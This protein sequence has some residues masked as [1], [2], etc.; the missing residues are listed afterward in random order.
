[1]TDSTLRE[2]SLVL[3]VEDVALMRNMVCQSLSESGFD[4]AEAATVEEGLRLADE[5]RP[6]IILLDVV[7]PDGDG[8]SV[9]RQLRSQPWGAMMPVVMMTGLDDLESIA[10]AFDAGATDFITKP[11]TWGILGHRVA[12]IIRSSRAEERIRTL[13]YFDPLTGLPNRT[14]FTEHLEML[15][16][17]ARRRQGNVAILLLD[18]DRFKKINETLGHGAGDRLLQE[19][20]Q[21]LKTAVRSSDTI[22]RLADEIL[23]HI[24]RFGGDEFVVTL[25]DAHNLAG[26][27]RV[28]QRLL[29][30]VA[31]PLTLDGYELFPSASIGISFFPTDGEDTAELLKNADTAMYHAK[32]Q[33][34]NNFQFYAREMNATAM[35]RLNLESHLRR[36]LERQEFL[37]HYQPQVETESGRITGLEALIRWPHAELGLIPP[38]RFISL[39]EETGLIFDLDEWV[40]RT[41]VRQI[42]QWRALGIEGVKVAVNLSGQHFSRRDLLPLLDAVI[43][44]EEWLARS[45]ELEIT[46]GV[47]MKEGEATVDI[48][49]GLRQRGITLAIDDFGTGYSSLSYLRRFPIDCLKIDKSFIRDTPDNADGVAIAAAIIAM[50]Q[51]LNLQVV[52]EGVE[53]E[54]QRAFL[55]SR[56][57]PFCQGYLFSP[58]LPVDELLPL[59][60]AGRI[61]P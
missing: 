57:C 4:L 14:H 55:A 1:M 31:L 47:L 25:A 40:L 60:Q 11:I 51:S 50:G 9:C 10:R 43:G 13:A 48:L 16:A 61:I 59:L 22:S 29:Q 6:D 38:D 39:A 45:L 12:Y 58:P 17:M 28:A 8:F 56:G 33:G 19:V 46:E 54:G 15:L 23:P 52:A 34:R 35:E 20:A 27:A 44:Q 5:L 21:R 7:L 37:L 42:S 32:N 41:V 36:A 18:L 24:S 3:V 53:T 2:R 30:K 26:I 49:R